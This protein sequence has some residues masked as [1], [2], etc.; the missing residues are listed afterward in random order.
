MMI[1]FDD[2][3]NVVNSEKE[4]KRKLLAII[5]KLKR[6]VDRYRMFTRSLTNQL[7]Q[8]SETRPRRSPSFLS[9]YRF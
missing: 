8:L 4:E 6:K 9:S 7:R 5:A 3:G 1:K 2:L